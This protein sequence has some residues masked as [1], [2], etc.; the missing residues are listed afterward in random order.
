[1]KSNKIL[2]LLALLVLGPLGDLVSQQLPISLNYVFRPG[3]GNPANVGA[4]DMN[5]FHLSH[6]QRK[7][8]IAGWRSVSQFINF[9]SQPLGKG[10]N[11]GLGAQITNDI[12]H[13]ENRLGIDGMVA[14]Q[15]VKSQRTRFSLGMNLGITNWTS[16]YNQVRIYHRDDEL[17]QAPFNF[18]ELNA[19]MGFEYELKL[20]KVRLDLGGYGTQLPGN[21]L[22]R[23]I[24]GLRVAPHLLG[25][26]ELMFSP[27][28]NLL[29]GPMAFYR[30]TFLRGDTVLR[31]GVADVG[32]KGELPRQD[33]WI[34]GAYR[35]NRSAL[36]VAFGLQI[37]LNDTAGKPEKT[38]LIADMMA[39]FSYP[40]QDGS[41]FG[42]TFEIG[43]DISFG[44]PYRRFK[45]KD[46]VRFV[47]GPFWENDGNLNRHIDEFLKINGPVG[48][49]GES[50]VRKS[51]VNITYFFPDPSLQYLGTTPE[52]DGD[53][54]RNVGMEWIGVDGL[55]YGVVNEV[56]REALT[57][58]TLHVMNPEVLEALK[59]LVSVELS[60]DLKVSEA[61]VDELAEAMLYE[62]EFG[63]NNGSE[64]TLFLSVVYN[65]ADTL[66]GIPLN[67]SITNLELAILKLHS[68]QKKLEFEMESRYGEEFAIVLEDEE[69]DPIAV[70]GKKIVTLKKPRITPNHPHQDA[71]QINLLKLKFTRNSGQKVDSKGRVIPDAY[72]DDRRR[73]RKNKNGPK[74]D[75]R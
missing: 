31:R 11:F 9:N 49:R 44:K 51:A 19:G 68:M 42:P 16:N 40:M 34:G 75:R 5:N 64:D 30:N 67:R 22:S 32:F 66:A 63:T 18:S 13:T 10:G 24:N 2:F 53:T 43:L 8:G 12:E 14:V 47:N 61:E 7:V 56:I 50:Y 54:L 72:P 58:D 6:Q 71:F 69:Y 59:G 52:F 73:G 38:V 65:G 29:V 62:G 35:I 15:L 3:I 55:L 21:F 74:R 36:S 27:A 39:G 23:Q 25:G 20:K 41:T 45:D 46:T 48:L 57:P 1:M 70:A 37:Y 26:G 28:H 4:L 33:M 17:L 60:S